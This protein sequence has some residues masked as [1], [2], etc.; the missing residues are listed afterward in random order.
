MNYNPTLDAFR[1]LARGPAN[2]IPV[3][4]EFAADLE[5]PVS[6]YLKL[7]EEPGASFLLESVEGGEQV[8]RYSFVGVGIHR[9]I[10]LHGETIT[11]MDEGSASLEVRA[12]QEREP[13]GSRHGDI[14]D[15]LRAE[16]GRYRAAAVSGNCSKERT[17]S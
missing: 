16:L 17:T 8:G 14:L 13:P 6:V 15:T 4:R 7:M 5:T 3:T 1:A 10:E 2:L 9:R 11:R 12:E